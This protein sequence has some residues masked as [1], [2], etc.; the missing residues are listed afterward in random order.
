MKVVDKE[1]V[2]SLLKDD[3]T[4]MIGGFMANGT[5]EI[6]I[7]AVLEKGT[8]GITVIANDAGY[9]DKGIG[10]LVAD[11]RVKKLITSHIGLNPLAGQQMNEGKM[12]VVLVPQG[13][14]AE[15]IRAKGAGLGGVLTPTGIGTDVANGKEIVTVDGKEFLLE[16]PLS[17][18]LAFI[19]GTYIDKAG[20]VFYK[21]TTRN[22]NPLMA[23]AAD[24]VVAGCEKLVEVGEIQNENIVTP[25]IFV[26][27]VVE[28]EK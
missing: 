20:N 12:E 27:Y 13:T 19:R 26:D 16:K 1:F 28:G 10:R 25:C 18:D 11:N 22:F 15:Q 24:V 7:D 4:I 6:L 17:A 8:K 14:L 23:T 2:K 3:M 9:P 5:P 21:G